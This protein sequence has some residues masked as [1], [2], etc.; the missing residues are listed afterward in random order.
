MSKFPKRIDA[1]LEI[2]VDEHLTPKERETRLRAKKAAEALSTA[3]IC[4]FLL[5]IIVG[6]IGS[7][8][9]NVALCISASVLLFAAILFKVCQAISMRVY[10]NPS[11]EDEEDGIFPYG[12]WSYL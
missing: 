10:N 2:K 4:S 6:L 11:C 12:P 7:V 5:S 8:C 1:R 9:F 3:A